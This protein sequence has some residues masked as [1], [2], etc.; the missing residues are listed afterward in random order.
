MLGATRAFAAPASSALLPALVKIERLP[1]AIALSSTTFQISTIGGPALGGLI[2]ALGGPDTAYLT[3][4]SCL[5]LAAVSVALLETRLPPRP[6]TQE[7]ATARVL[8]GL[9]YVLSERVLL[10]AISLDLA[11]VLLGGAVALMPIFARDILHVGELGL[12]ILRSAPAVGAALMAVLFSLY[13][14]KRHAGR[15]MFSGVAI[16]GIATIVF[17]MSENFTLS[18]VALAVLGGADMMSVV[19]RQSLVQLRTPDEMRGRVSSV[20]Y[21]FIGASNELGEFESG[22][23]AAWLGTVRAVVLGGVGTLVVTGLWAT[24]FPTLRK[25]DRLDEGLHDEP[26]S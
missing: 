12:G 23:T 13:P 1:R 22:L 16:F 9:R 18:L 2:Y 11:A 8:A 20:S 26:P 15:F 3:A 19:V 17:G 7:S 14:M 21:I 25:A 6:P 5:G 10:G 24:L 4:A